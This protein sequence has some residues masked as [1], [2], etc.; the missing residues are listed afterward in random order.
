MIAWRQGL[1][2]R[3]AAHA[4]R[5]RARLPARLGSRADGRAGCCLHSPFCFPIQRIR[6]AESRAGGWGPRTSQERGRGGT[7]GASGSVVCRQPRRRG[8]RAGGRRRS[9]VAA[10]RGEA[11]AERSR[12]GQP[13]WR[14]ARRPG[15]HGPGLLPLARGFHRRGR[16]SSPN[17][18]LRRSATDG[19]SLAGSNPEFKRSQHARFCCGTQGSA[20][21][22]SCSSRRSRQCRAG[23]SP[24]ASAR[25]GGPI[26]LRW[27]PCPDGGTASPPLL[28]RPPTH[29]ALASLPAA[30]ARRLRFG[31]F[32]A[33]AAEP[34]SLLR[35]G[36]AHTSRSGSGSPACRGRS[37]QGI[38]CRQRRSQRRRLPA[39]VGQ[40]RP[41]RELLW[42]GEAMM[43][44]LGGNSGTSEKLRSTT[45][46]DCAAHAAPRARDCGHCAKQPGGSQSAG[47]RSRH[48]RRVLG[49][50]T[51][52]LDSSWGSDESQPSRSSLHCQQ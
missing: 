21:G 3:I 23:R 47:N 43:M 13:S 9:G 36:R 41:E 24:P 42:T 22:A 8:G 18:Y 10:F 50:C 37:L 28:C 1:W 29:D 2:H 19:H 14:R 44:A 6:D 48:G 38:G 39:P 34:S 15:G 26:R 35:S 52:K 45:A 11:A 32:R 25:L 51:G 16:R 33:A 5:A 17:H 46:A 40:R 27:A 4:V 12:G 7:A 20:S 30:T 49:D 31:C